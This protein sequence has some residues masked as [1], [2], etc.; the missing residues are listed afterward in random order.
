MNTQCNAPAKG[1][2]HFPES[3]PRLCFGVEGKALDEPRESFS[4]P[5]SNPAIEIAQSKYGVSDLKFE[6]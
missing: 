1:S 6:T 2:L 3:F 5:F 4:F